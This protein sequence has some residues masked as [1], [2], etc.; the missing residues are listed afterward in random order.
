MDK[1]AHNQEIKDAYI[2]PYKIGVG[3][4]IDEI[5]C[6][7]LRNRPEKR[8]R[9]LQNW[10]KYPIRF[11]TAEPDSDPFRGCR[12]SHIEVVKYA[13]SRG[14]K[15][16]L[17]LEDDTIINKDLKD[18]PKFPDDWDTIYLGGLCTRPIEWNCK[19]SGWNRGDIWC[20][21]AYIVNNTIF[22]KIIEGAPNT[23]TIDMFM[24]ENV[25]RGKRAYILNENYVV[26][27]EGYSDLNKKVKWK[28]FTWPKFGQSFNHP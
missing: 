8:E 21:H 14:Y 19:G 5:V 15:N 20:C 4:D 2:G 16:I 6:I 22:D 28:G 18:V 7:N 9:M 24:V 11:Y 27:E 26:Q 23:K 10:S 25:C 3:K 13:K 17:I 12:N 1:E